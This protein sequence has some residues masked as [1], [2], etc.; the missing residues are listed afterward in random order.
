MEDERGRRAVAGGDV[1]DDLHGR[2]E[3]GEEFAFTLVQDFDRRLSGRLHVQ[4]A[5]LLENL[6]FQIDPLEYERAAEE[7]DVFRG[8]DR[9]AGD[10]NPVSG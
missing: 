1:E 6:R 4:E 9:T 3:G 2:V 8:G 7:R 10:Q 5:V